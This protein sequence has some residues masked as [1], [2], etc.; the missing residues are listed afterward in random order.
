MLRF[1]GSD[2]GIEP[3]SPALEV[4]SLLPEPP[5]KPQYKWYSYYFFLR[6]SLRA[7]AAGTESLCTPDSCLACQQVFKALGLLEPSPQDIFP[8]PVL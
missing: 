4:D 7:Q 6:P 5:G 8:A 3:R 1:M 2:P